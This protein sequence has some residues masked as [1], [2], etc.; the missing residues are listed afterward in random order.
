MQTGG[1]GAELSGCNPDFSGARGNVGVTQKA[2]VAAAGR[3]A[4]L[5]PSLHVRVG[6]GGQAGLGS[7]WQRQGESSGFPEQGGRNQLRK[8]QRWWHAWRGGG[9]N[10]S[11]TTILILHAQCYWGRGRGWGG[12]G[13][14]LCAGGQASGSLG[15][16]PSVLFQ[17]SPSP[18]GP[19]APQR[20]DPT[21]GP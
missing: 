6:K 20:K 11:P 15:W 2:A 1:E 7:A 9:E 12:N 16:G 13:A 18:V 5:S 3:G 4:S 14:S 10:P 8:R 21:S 17:K 19:D